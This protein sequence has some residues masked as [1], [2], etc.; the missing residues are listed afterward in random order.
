MMHDAQWYAV[1]ST[2]CARSWSTFVVLIVCLITDHIMLAAKNVLN[3]FFS[4][5]A[6]NGTCTTSCGA[7][8]PVLTVIQQADVLLYGIYILHMHHYLFSLL[9]V[10]IYRRYHAAPSFHICLYLTLCTASPCSS[11]CAFAFFKYNT[12]TW[13]ITYEIFSTSPLRIVKIHIQ[14]DGFRITL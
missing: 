1:P 9:R 2:F 13:N 14:S 11:I 7:S 10:Y 6:Q 5:V 12:K 3:Y 4:T 8:S